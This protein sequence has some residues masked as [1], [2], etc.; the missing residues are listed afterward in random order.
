MQWLIV[1]AL[2]KV[3]K[4][5]LSTSSL[6]TVSQLGARRALIGSMQPNNLCGHNIMHKR[7]GW[8]MLCLYGYVQNIM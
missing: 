2:S 1:N 7:L 5:L 3:V 8:S 6:T 4:V